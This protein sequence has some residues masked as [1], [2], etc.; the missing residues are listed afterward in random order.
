MAC[1]CDQGVQV[2][3]HLRTKYAFVLGTVAALGAAM[4]YQGSAL[5]TASGGDFIVRCFYNGNVAAMDPIIAPGSTTTDHLHVFFGNLVQGTSTFPTIT[6]GDAGA[7]GTMENA[8]GGGP[9]QTNCQDSADTAGYWQPAIVN[10]Y[11]ASPCWPNTWSGI[12]T[13]SIRHPSTATM[14]T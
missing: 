5:A 8:S 4:A 2:R 9:Q 14:T 12:A 6:S 11:Q 7:K 10:R 13:S 1:R 3:R